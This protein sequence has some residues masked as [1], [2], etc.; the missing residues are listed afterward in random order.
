MVDKHSA[1]D[2]FS[3]MV[4][5]FVSFIIG[6]TNSQ[7]L[8]EQSGISDPLPACSDYL[9]D[10]QTY[11]HCASKTAITD[12]DMNTIHSHCAH[13]L[14]LE[15]EC[16][17]KWVRANLAKYDFNS[18]KTV[19]NQDEDCVF[20]LL[21]N[22]PDED[23]LV[24]IERCEQNLHHFRRDCVM[25]AVQRWYFQWPP[26][27]EMERISQSPSRN[28]ELIGLYVG[29]RVE[30]DG[31]GACTGHVENKAQCERYV[32]DYQ[33]KSKCPNQHRNRKSTRKWIKPTPIEQAN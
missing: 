21:D 18:L 12:A 1:R 30:C 26:D 32:R 25:H 17:H 16:R 19:C 24:Q 3:H 27:W 15:M 14:D 10:V 8:V 7:S 9:N 33:D 22:T 2:Y 6:C 20:D 13:A 5:I 4:S 23:V 11:K 31:I 28:A 29:A